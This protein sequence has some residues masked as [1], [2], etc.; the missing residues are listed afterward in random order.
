MCVIFLPLHAVIIEPPFLLPNTALVEQLGRIIPQPPA[1]LVIAAWIRNEGKG[2]KRWSGTP[3]LVEQ[4]LLR[5]GD[6]LIH[7]DFADGRGAADSS[8][9]S[10]AS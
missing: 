1:A 7:E 4:S 10:F 3:A 2:R 5:R 8:V 6:G 9:A